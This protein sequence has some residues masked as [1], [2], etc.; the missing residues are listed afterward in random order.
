MIGKE[1]HV[2]YQAVPE[3][4]ARVGVNDELVERARQGHEDLEVVRLNDHRS[5][6][7]IYSLLPD[8]S[9][10]QLGL[11]HFQHEIWLRRFAGKYWMVAVLALVL[12]VCA[13]SLMAARALQPIREVTRTASAISG[14]SLG[15]RVPVSGRGD[16]VDRLA[17][18][19]NGMLERIDTL[20]DGLRSVT[21]SLA[22]DLR[23]P[24]TGMR[25]IA[26]VTLRLHREPS[27]YRR[28]LHQIMEQLDRLLALSNSI[29]DVAEAESGALALRIEEVHLDRLADDMVQTFGAVAA[30]K[31]IHLDATI[32]AGLSI[33][34]D[35]G[36]LCQVMA[37]LLDNALKYTQ[38]GSRI[39]LTVKPHPDLRG[40]EIKVA[41]TGIGIT[42][43]D[44]PHIF[45]RYYRA[46]KSRFGPGAGL[47]LTL[48]QGIV[49]AHGGS[50]TVESAP[51]EGSVFH[52]FLPYD[53][54]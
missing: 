38:S 22:H 43:K 7:I 42:E 47:G 19:F 49:K 51:E 40:I 52:V 54:L 12:S 16:E 33:K 1:G 8:E 3:A 53:S 23:T 28:V 39:S 37:N 13:G 48:V 2:A 15:Q 14:R 46:D 21:D 9:V 25:G 30:D 4:C 11:T 31:G 18:A 36:R 5:L 20:I 6:R 29:L 45:E 32:S 27:E 44:L 17:D 24:I 50:V 35:R 34:G 26:E 41:D 10:I